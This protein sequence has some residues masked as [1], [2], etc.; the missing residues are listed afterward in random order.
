MKFTVLASGS[1]ANSIVVSSGGTSV[2]IDCG[3]SAKETF[4]RLRSRG[5]CE[6]DLSAILITHEHDDHI[7]GVKALANYTGLPIYL[8]EGTYQSS[9]ILRNLPLTQVR[10]F[11]PYFGFNIKELEIYPFSVSH[12]AADPV[13]F[14]IS[15]GE[16]S[17]GIL[18]DLG[19]FS[20]REVDIVNGVDALLIEANHDLD[21]LWKTHY[22]WS[23]KERIA[24]NRGHLSNECASRFIFS[25]ERKLIKVP[26]VIVATHISE[27]SNSLDL[28]RTALSSAWKGNKSPIFEPALQSE[29]S[30]LYSL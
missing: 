12:D 15:D 8:T 30:E 9:E 27:N 5:L 14:K 1:K 19:V 21:K 20:E 13:C 4:L 11:D 17:I 7:R 6:G 18:S 10:F 26:R 3:L 29:A 22:P 28:A 24:G 23:V 25:F 2:L 16:K